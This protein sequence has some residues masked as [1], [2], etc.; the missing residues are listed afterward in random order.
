ML[1]YRNFGD[2]DLWGADFSA[3]VIMTQEWSMTVTGSYVS[4]EFFVFE[5]QGE[6]ALN[7]PT[8]KGAIGLLYDNARV[9]FDTG[10]RAQL[11]RF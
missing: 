4:D 9:G 11:E 6:I 3:Q 2:V 10:I 1:A 7:A 5:D 8:V